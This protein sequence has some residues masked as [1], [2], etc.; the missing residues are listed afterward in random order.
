MLDCEWLSKVLKSYKNC[1]KRLSAL[2]VGISFRCA[3]RRNVL[4]VVIM[5]VCTFSFVVDLSSWKN[6]IMEEKSKEYENEEVEVE[7]GT[8]VTFFAHST[9]GR[10]LLAYKL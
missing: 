4:S 3:V 10:V 7:K 8:E 1:A 5:P 6:K 9:V 2:K